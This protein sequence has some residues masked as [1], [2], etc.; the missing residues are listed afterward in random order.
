MPIIWPTRKWSDPADEFLLSG[1]FFPTFYSKNCKVNSHGH[2]CSHAG[3]TR[4]RN[5]SFSMTSKQPLPLKLSRNLLQSLD[6]TNK[7]EH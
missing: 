4:P 1:P 3:L 6:V 5:P 7:I 2:R